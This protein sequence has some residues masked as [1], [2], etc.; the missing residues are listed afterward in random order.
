[1]AADG[2]IVIDVTLDDGSVVQGLGRINNQLGDTGE[3]GSTMFGK[4]GKGIKTAG[5]AAAGLV[6]GVGAVGLAI[7]GL[8]AP[9]VRAAGDVQALNA[10]FETVFNGLEDTATAALDR[11]GAETGVATGRLKGSFVQIAA[12]AKTSGADTATALDITS[13]ATLAAADSA[14]F[15]D[16]SIEEV[17]ENLQSF[18]KGNYENDA[19]L[20]IS[21]TETTRNAAAMDEFGKKFKDLTEIQK[22]QTL[23][24]MVEDGNALGGALGQAARETGGLENVLGNLSDAWETLKAKLG[25]QI[26]DYAITALQ[27]LTKTINEFDITPI[28]NAF[29]RVKLVLSTILDTVVPVVTE[30]LAMLK[31]LWASEGEGILTVVTEKFNMIKG[32]IE[33]VLNVVVPF[34]QEQIGKI[35]EFWKKD[36]EQILTAVKNA[37]EGVKKV[38]DFIMPAVL[39]VIEYVWDAIKNVISG[40]LDIIMGAVKVFSGLFTG[41]FSKLWEGVKQIFS[42]AIDVIL[43]LMS[44]SFIG[45]IRTAIVNFGKT[46]INLFK[47][48]WTNIIN[49]VKSFVTNFGSS[50]SGMVTNVIQFFRNMATNSANTIMQMSINVVGKVSSMATG[51]VNAIK[52]LPAQFLSFG[53]DIVN[54]LIKGITG[55]VEKAVDAIKGVGSAVKDKFQDVMGIFSPSREFKKFGKWTVEGYQIGVEENAKMATGAIEDLGKAII[56]IGKNN[57]KE[58]QKLQDE[59]NKKILEIQKDADTKLANLTKT[60]MV[61]KKKV[62]VDNSKAIAKIEADEAKKIATEQQKL[63]KSKLAITADI[64]KQKLDVIKLY[65]EDKKSLEDLSIKE[66]IKIWA[67]AVNTFKEGTKE[68]IEAQKQYKTLTESIGKEIVSI[69]E[70]YTKQMNDVDTKLIEDIKKVNEEYEKELNSRT[71]SYTNFKK[72]F[73][74]FVVDLEISGTDLL[75]NLQSQVTG[76]KTW[77]EQMDIFASRGIASDALV[78]ELRTLGPNSLSELTALNSLSDQ[79]LTIYA[80]LF[81]EKAKLAREQAEKELVGMKGDTQKRITEMTEEANKKLTTL[82]TEWGNKI[83]GVTERTK[84]ELSSLSQIGADAGQGLYDGLASKEGLLLE[85]AA[86]IA[87]GIKATIQSALDIHS[88]SRWMRDFVAGNLAKGFSIGVDKYSGTII[89]ASDKMGELIKMDVTNP[90]RNAT[91]GLGNISQST[92]PY[93]YGTSSTTS[94][95]NSRTINAPITIVDGSNDEQ[96]ISREMRKLQFMYGN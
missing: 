60:K 22:Q 59:S 14:A 89:K 10:Q 37:F 34:V 86:Q 11:I 84:T 72:L 27:W 23:L 2:T 66:E 52:G 76:F 46:A 96:A 71:S 54:G 44:L 7:G 63:E 68:R 93:N 19:A 15:Y 26:F 85:K 51:M 80:G 55:N 3:Q 33:D 92:N 1:M 82:Q 62:I 21:A 73:D 75:A 58:E 90:L 9:L 79:S 47:T 88:P 65:V 83:K 81:E 87:E 16:R 20:G 24:K 70:D 18:L 29:E 36:G 25:E 74:E 56:N 32:V 8:A 13:R 39:F 40:A 12:F 78:E 91:L 49:G 94:N 17:T 30:K 43:G 31:E 61:K 67:T 28:V 50:I 6:A 4:I 57:A 48:N 64:Q 41:D 95:N 38:I 77:Q 42:G 35:V 45:G 69:N 53:K 5:L